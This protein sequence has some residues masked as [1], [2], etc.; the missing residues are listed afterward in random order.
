MSRR[1]TT[2]MV[3]GKFMPPHL[4]H[5][6]L[7][8][9]AQSYV[10]DLSIVVGT[11]PT[12]PI[13]GALRYRWMRELMP[14]ARV[15]H[16]DEVL[17]QDPSEHADFWGLWERALR[18]VLPAQPLDYVFAS[19]TYGHR[20][21]EVLGA[22][23]VPV[24]QARSV[25]PVSGTAIRE[26]PLESWSFL[27]P[28]VRPYFAK[29]ICVYGPESTGKSTLAAYLA[30]ELETVHVPEY[31]RTLI[32]MKRGEVT[33][34]DIERI[35]RGQ[36]AS[37]EALARRANRV[38]VCDTD[39]ITTTIW[40]HVLFGECPEW[41]REEAVRRTY[42]LYLLCD[43]DVPWVDD[44]VRYLPQERRSFFERCRAELEARGRPYVEIRGDWDA[45]QRRALEAVRALL[46]D[47]PSPTASRSSR[48]DIPPVGGTAPADSEDDEERD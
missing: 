25:V 28:L 48:E 32:E 18:R 35:A 21:A 23:F 40:S 20:L 19:E 9:F 3:L 43:V 30:R 8:E 46:D 34:E 42:D 24:D 12:E 11:L 29:R 6:Y 37:E 4:G 7:T 14:N 31:A 10:D 33:L 41:I 15:I 26:R 44:V 2:G 1:P 5:L 13:D 27:P 16:L 47:G 38:L 45:R 36:M 22:E 17:P 39:L